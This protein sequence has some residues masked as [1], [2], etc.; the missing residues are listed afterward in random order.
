MFLAASVATRRRR[1]EAC[2]ASS[3]RGARRSN[4][5]RRN[6]RFLDTIWLQGLDLFAGACATPRD[7]V[8]R[9]TS[10]SV[11][12]VEDSPCQ[13]AN[14]DE[15]A[16]PATRDEERPT[17]DA[18]EL[19]VFL[20]SSRDLLARVPRSQEK[21][22]LRP[23]RQDPVRPAPFSW[24]AP[25]ASLACDESDCDESCDESDCDSL[26]DVS[27][28]WEI[29]DSTDYLDEQLVNSFDVLSRVHQE[30]DLQVASHEHG[31][32]FRAF[33]IEPAASLSACQLDSDDDSS[34][35]DEMDDED[36]YGNCGSHDEG[37]DAQE[38]LPEASRAG[39]AS[40]SSSSGS[41]SSLSSLSS[42][43]GLPAIEAAAAATS[44]LHSPRALSLNSHGAALAA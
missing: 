8:S 1:P 39:W 44:P 2:C 4:P 42:S 21:S 40:S 17:A 25:G 41:S 16:F 31:E 24:A 14:G 15:R 19:D 37:R 3:R 35:S 26:S 11:G 20:A 32:S 10:G 7:D 30:S 6:K 36:F 29:P 27:D 12:E 13:S 34:Y 38:V 23:L 28:L 22:L 5:V 43:E 18:D 9:T 33:R